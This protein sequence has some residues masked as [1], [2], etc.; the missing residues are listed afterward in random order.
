[1]TRKNIFEILKSNYDVSK[2]MNKITILFSS[3]LCYYEDYD[4]Y[5]TKHTIGITL[6]EIFD[7]EIL[8]KWKQRGTFL[9]YKEIREVIGLNDVFTDKTPTHKIISC[10]E[11]YYNIL[12]LI[13]VKFDLSHNGKYKYDRTKLRFM[14]ENMNILTDYLHYKKYPIEEDEKVILIPKDP[15]AIAVAEISTKN[16]AIAILQ[17]HHDSLKGNLDEKRKL[18]IAIAHEYEA[19]LKNPIDGF[20]DFFKKAKDMLNNL[21]IRHNNT[22][23]KNKK[24]LLMNMSDADLEKWYDEL[25]QL[26]LF[27]VLIKD[28]V[29][30][31]RDIEEF[32]KKYIHRE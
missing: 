5:L 26:L 4:R 8:P 13:L 27:C 1:M 19:L 3:K 31:K 18:L 22:M 11:Y 32:L 14:I 15:A 7:I 24:D 12:H 9:S 20:S 29:K 28:N 6:E 25:Y 23:G 21:N 30:R 2:E 10:L 17:Y 16:T